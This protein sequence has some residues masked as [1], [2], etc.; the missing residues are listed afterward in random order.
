M[1]IADILAEAAEIRFGDELSG[2]CKYDNKK[3][4][5]Q[6]FADNVIVCGVAAKPSC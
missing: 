6:G 4:Y 2:E 5:S 1:I 3:S